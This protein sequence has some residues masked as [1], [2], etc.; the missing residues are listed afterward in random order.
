VDDNNHALAALRY[1]VTKLD[2]GRNVRTGPVET[3]ED[4]ARKREEYERRKQREWLSVWN[5]ELWRRID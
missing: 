5:E 2:A 4:K 3:P 1:L